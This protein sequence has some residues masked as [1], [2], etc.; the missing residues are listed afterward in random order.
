VVWEDE[1]EGRV[2]DAAARAA[3][4]LR[5]ALGEH[6]VDVLGP[7]PAPM[8]LLRGRHRWHLLLKAPLSG[9]GMSRA[10]AI[11][12]DLQTQRPRMA[13]DVDPASMM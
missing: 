1:E 11:L 10:R 6:K 5:E 7:A 13:I 4:I 9:Q 12:A 3:T 8:A 2:K